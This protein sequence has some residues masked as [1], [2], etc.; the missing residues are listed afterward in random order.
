[1][2]AD[3]LAIIDSINGQTEAFLQFGVS[4]YYGLMFAVG[5][6]VGSFR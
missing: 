4:V 2:S 5:A 1:M 3:T 6:V